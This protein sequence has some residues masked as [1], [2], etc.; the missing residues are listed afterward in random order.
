MERYEITPKMLISH[1][2]ERR[3]GAFCFL[4]HGTKNETSDGKSRMLDEMPIDAD[5]I[6][7]ILPPL[8]CFGEHQLAHPVNALVARLDAEMMTLARGKEVPVFDLRYQ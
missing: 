6:P 7:R 2:C 5:L 1:V 8:Q 3:R 4:Q